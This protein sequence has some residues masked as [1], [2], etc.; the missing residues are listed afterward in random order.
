MEINQAATELSV[1]KK[2]M[3][4]SRRINIDNGIH[5]IFW[6]VLVS[7]TLLANYFMV[8]YKVSLNYI[9]L[10][11]M[12]IMIAGA[13]AGSFI[14][15]YQERTFRVKTYAGRLL[16]SLWFAS[17][18][19]M[20]TYGFIGIITGAYNAIYCCPIIAVSLGISYYTSGAIQ[21]IRWLQYV[22]AGWWLG[23]WA[24]FYMKSVHILLVFAIMM[25]C[26]QLIPGIVLFNKSKREESALQNYEL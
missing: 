20:F 12:I 1:I 19:S 23:G 9:G 4:D 6:G 14:N 16:G 7:V 5:Y 26:F 15:K 11:W 13:V 17:G 18:V 10:M 22:A 3:E 21:Q 8:L 25:I 24:L 2:I